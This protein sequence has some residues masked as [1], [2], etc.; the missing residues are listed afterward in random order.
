MKLEFSWQ[1]FDKKNLSNFVKIYPVG[2]GLFNTNTQT[3]MLELIV[4]FNNFTKAPKNHSH[5]DEQQKGHTDKCWYTIGNCN[6][7]VVVTE[8]WIYQVQFSIV[9][10]YFQISQK[11]SNKLHTVTQSQLTTPVKRYK[12]SSQTVCSVITTVCS[13]QIHISW[14]RNLEVHD[15][16]KGRRYS[17]SCV[18]KQE[19]WGPEKQLHTFLFSTVHGSQWPYSCTDHCTANKRIKWPMN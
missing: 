2:A 11:A 16:R 5:S 10:H 4:T 12:R 15:I 18:Q 6:V 3:A 8:R 14:H 9:H 1:I 7:P 17:C 19:T 13:Q